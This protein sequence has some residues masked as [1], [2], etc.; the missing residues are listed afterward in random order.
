MLAFA[1]WAGLLIVAS[2]GGSHPTAAR[3]ANFQNRFR[4]PPAES[5]ILKII[6]S[7]PDDAGEQD[8]L[9]RALTNQG[10]GGVVCNVSFTDYLESD[11]RWQ[12]FVRAV[13]AAKQAG[14]ALW[15]YDEKGYPSGSA[16]G[17]VLRDHPEWEARGLLI[18][19]AT[20]ESG[21]VSVEMPPGR[22]CVA[23]AFPV[24]DDQIK[25][26]E[27][28][29]ITAEV[30]DGKLDWKTP[31]GRW[32]VMA[33][34]ESRLFEGTHAS[35]SLADHI[36]YPNLLQAEPTARFLELTHQRYAQHL[37]TNLGRFLISTFTD[38]P[39]LM[40]LFL[41]PMPYRVLPWSPEFPAVFKK[42]R[43][44]ALEPMI[45]ALVA[46]AG[47]EGSKVRYDYW[48]T[49][50]ELVAASYFGQIQ[51]WCAGHQVL[52]GGHLLM[53][54]NLV[55]QVPLYGDFF[56]CL[57][58]LDAPGIDCLT[59]IPDQVP[60]FIAR[61]AS[62][63]AELEGKTVTMCETSD[64]SQRYRPAGDQRPIRKVTPEEIRGTCNRLIVAGIDTITSYY[65]FDGL[66]DEQLRELNLWV[67]R[68][69]A[70]LK[71]GHQ[72]ADIAVLYP[73]QS[74]W[75]RFTPARHY[76]HDS[77]AAAEVENLYHE[78]SEGLFATGRD[79]TYVDA[80]ALVEAKVE[81]GA[82]VHGKL[83]WRVVILPGGDTLPQKAWENLQKFVRSSGILVSVGTLPANSE[84]EFPAPR[85]RAFAAEAFG[86]PTGKPQF[87]ANSEGGAGIF[88][89]AG[90]SSL[91]PM[92]INR[93]LAPDIGV[94]SKGSPIR[95]T[96]RQI[97]GREVFFLINDSAKPFNDRITLAALG[98]GEQCDPA[99]GE[100]QSVPAGSAIPLNL[101]A[102]GGAIFRFQTALPPQLRKLDHDLLPNLEFRDL[103]PVSP[104]IARGEFV[105]E[106]WAPEATT[107]STTN[108][109]WRVT[110]TLTKS[111]VD[112]HL[113][114]RFPFPNSIDIS[115]ADS[116]VV[117]TWVPAGQHTP[118]Q[119]LVILHEKNGA[120]YLASTGRMLGA[121]GYSQTFVPLTRFQLAGWSNDPNGHLDLESIAEIR[122]GW[123]GYF[124]TERET[125]QFSLSSPRTATVR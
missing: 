107:S 105:R 89:P 13:A 68:C 57:R 91:L 36:P 7:W 113:F 99:T 90:S 114:V 6:H 11:A 67:G 50:G 56:Q 29:D 70:S 108:N 34:T 118:T 98:A 62:S 77:P 37:G 85:V 31:P 46:D 109:T 53:E 112:T 23:A 47:A 28:K 73:I 42:R 72:V 39:S 22:L 17:L 16:G 69:C 26:K 115:E 66:S 84:A 116:L 78:V 82:L 40:S 35:L 19:D 18:A 88:L 51:R 8:R 10:F 52:S 119:L 30:R 1:L 9:I 83:R 44:Y 87:Q 79:F 102:Y 27:A 15:L 5:R 71:G 43:G 60:W 20:S 41:K 65:S 3:A 33:I 61:M 121:P 49:V 64:H 117:D 25:L 32:R 24:R 95:A 86:A 122:I 59:S 103:P 12:A 92:V 96:H 45:P 2:V 74:I 100:I 38:E 94:P 21:T 125:V 76:A 120:D 4:N 48:Q 111:Q 75:P 93:I 124:G 81:R 106:N 101:P 58:R 104:L 123:G 80:R 54:E 63:A 55:N 110:A 14:F 97:D